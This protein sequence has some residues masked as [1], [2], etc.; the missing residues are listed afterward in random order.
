MTSKPLRNVLSRRIDFG[1]RKHLAKLANG[2]GAGVEQDGSE[3]GVQSSLIEPGAHA[4]RRRHA[5]SRQ[6]PDLTE[7]RIELR[8]IVK[9]Q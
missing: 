9:R 4:A 3:R 8:V 5:L 2:G 7:E 1:I 6:L